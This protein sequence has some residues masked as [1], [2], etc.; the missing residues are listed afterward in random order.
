MTPLFIDS[1][2]W[3]AENL[4]PLI[5]GNAPLL[6]ELEAVRANPSALVDAVQ[7]R[8]ILAETRPNMQEIAAIPQTSYTA[9]RRFINDGDRVEYQTPYFAKRIRLASAALRLWL[10]VEGGSALK[11]VVEDYLW[12]V[13]EETNWVVPAHERLAIDLFASETAF[14]LAQLLDLLGD[15]IHWEV[16]H[17]V[18]CEI[19]RRVLSRS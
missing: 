15:Q 11:P 14:L 6:P 9:Y 19:N 13:C 5:A 12:N 17:R 2:D 18:L 16:R 1:I 3:T 7:T 10:G 8:Q 4:L